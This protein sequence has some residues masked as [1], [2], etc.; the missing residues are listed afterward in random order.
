M[1][2]MSTFARAGFHHL[3]CNLNTLHVLL[4]S[5]WYNGNYWGSIKCSLNGD[6]VEFLK[7]C[8]SNILLLFEKDAEAIKDVIMHLNTPFQES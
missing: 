7:F 8:P 6:E 2:G 5:D 3:F 4:E 1:A